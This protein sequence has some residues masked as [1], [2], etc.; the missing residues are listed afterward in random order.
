MLGLAPV[1][2]GEFA[3]PFGLIRGRALT[4][5]ARGVR[6]ALT[7]ARL[8]RGDWA[9]AVSDPQYVAFAT[10]D[11]VATAGRLAAAGAPLLPVPENYAD[12]L[13]ARFELAPELLAAIRRHG[14]MYDEDAA[15]GY[16]HLATL[17]L[18][19]RV[20]FEVVQRLG[21]YDGYG[22]ADAP[23]RMAAHRRA[24]AAR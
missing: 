24:R 13:A 7:V 20:F 11:I 1:T 5:E 12:D 4:D 17:V 3:A 21:G 23:V 18:G 6:L 19:D 22:T 16:L 10:D 9:P 8:R 2:A 15:G 14:L